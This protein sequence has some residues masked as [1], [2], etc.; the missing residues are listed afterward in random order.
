MDEL[1]RLRLANQHLSEACRGGPAQVVAALGAVQSQDY[2]AAKWAVGLRLGGAT[3]S[4]VEQAFDAGEIVRTHVLRPTWHFIAP[5]DI[6]WL[7]ALTAPRVKAATAYRDRVLGITEPLVERSN[8]AI[9]AALSGGQHLTRRE[10]DQVLRDSVV[11]PEDPQVFAH[12]LLRAELDGVI[13]SGPRRGKQFTYAL[14]E[15]RVPPAPVLDR[16]AALAEITRRYF[17]SHGPAT[18]RDLAWWSGLTIAEIKRGIDLNGSALSDRTI[19]GLTYWASSAV[20]DVPIQGDVVYLLPN[21]DE[22]TVAYRDRDLY[23]DS[24]RKHKHGSR[25]DVPFGNVIVWR[26]RVAGVW[27]RSA[28][29]ARVKLE[30]DWFSDVETDGRGAVGAAAAR[31]AAFLESPLAL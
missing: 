9:T 30:L 26:G 15:E 11:Q 29:E 5:A 27:K 31:Y 16:D 19:D 1:L 2:P 8:A 21:Y 20:A 22:Y 28:R 13:C 3:D 18:L 25:I 17:S 14:L 24:W 23:Y 4:M 12:L 6:R 10:L 7:L